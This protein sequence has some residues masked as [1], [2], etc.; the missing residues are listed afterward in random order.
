VTIESSICVAGDRRARVRPGQREQALLHD[1]HLLDRQLD[2]EVAAGDHDAVRHAQELLGA[3]DRLRLLDLRDERRARVLA[4]GGDVLGPAHERDGDHVDAHPQPGLQMG[5]VLLGDGGQRRGLAR[6]VEALARGD[7]A[8]DLDARVDLPVVGAHRLRAQ[9]DGAVGQVEHLAGLDRV[10]EALPGDRH[11]PRVALDALVGPARERHDVARLELGH[12][13]AQLADAQLGAG[14][15]LQD[16]DRPSGAARGRP[17]ALG[18][19]GVLLVR[20]VREVQAR[21]VEARLDHLDQDL[22]ILRGRADGRHDLR[23]PHRPGVEHAR[24]PRVRPGG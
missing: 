7:G 20:A 1:R 22:G 10:G 16:R 6:D 3:V 21:D 14:E 18:R 13:V 4:D 11:V 12:A 17:D 19:L 15:V 5:E 2:A 8:A 9:P 23:S 24:A